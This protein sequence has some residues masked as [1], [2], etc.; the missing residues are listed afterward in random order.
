MTA[1]H[2]TCFLSL[3]IHWGKLPCVAW[4]IVALALASVGLLFMDRTAVVLS[5]TESARKQDVSPT[6]IYFPLVLNRENRASDG[7][8]NWGAPIALSPINASIWSVNPDSASVSVV[9]AEQLS[10]VAEIRVGHEPWSLAIAPDGSAVYVINR[11]D[12]TLTVID[13][14]TH[15][16]RTTLAVGP[17]PGAIALSPSG[18]HAYITLTS[19]QAL[20]IVD[21]SHLTITAQITVAAL[22]Y[23]VAVTDDGDSIDDDERI[24]VTHLLTFAHS[25]ASE[26]TDTG[27]AGRVTVIDA[28][29]GAIIREIDLLP[30][31]HGFPNLLAGIALTK[32]HIWLPHSRAAPALPNGLTTTLFAA[33]DAIDLQ[34]ESEDRTAR[35]LLNDELIFGSPVNNPLAAIPAPDGKTLYVVLAGSNLVEIIDIT[36]PTHPHLIKFL[37]TGHN[38]RGMA[39]SADGKRGYVMNYLGRSISVL[40]LEQ[41]EVDREL[42]VTTEPLA[43]DL[44]RGKILFNRA[45]D[46]R[47]TQ[48][49]WIS[50]A[51][52]HLDGGTDSVTWIFPDGPRQTPALWN[53]GQTLPWHWSAAPA[54][55][56]WIGA[57]PWCRSAATGRRERRSLG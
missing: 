57:C 38:P 10:V 48:G 35:L 30:D 37:P 5:Y 15:L 29:A 40:N 27:R 6:T 21:T 12:G 25:T 54:N 22:P 42:Q 14:T 20:A 55:P 31:G 11:A 13:A 1:F 2:G 45:T 28:G 43:P 50:C 33:V 16:V 17:E 49:S 8:P 19:A 3:P 34:T 9:D 46:P 47:L 32:D 7:R 24:Y 53:A 36:D 41:N 18:K 44:L 23:A 51:N 4:S 39:I 56:A 26:A 52:C